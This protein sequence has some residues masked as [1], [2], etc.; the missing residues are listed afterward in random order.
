MKRILLLLAACAWMAQNIFAD[1]LDIKIGQMILMGI[2]QRKSI[3]DNDSLLLDIKAG[4]LGGVL[5]F[6]KNIS[7]SNATQKLKDLCAKLQSAANIP[8]FISIDEEGGKVHRLKEKYGFVAMP[9][10]S[11]LGKINNIDSTYYYNNRLASELASLGINLNFAPSVDLRVNE[12]NKVIVQTGRSFSSDPFIVANNANA[13][14]NAHHN[15]GVYTSLKHFPGHGSSLD[16]SHLGLV[17]V[18]NTWSFEELLPYYQILKNGNCDAVMIA[19]LINKNWDTTKT[20]STLSYRVVTDILRNLIG[21][22]GLTF[23]DDMQ[24]KAITKFY[25]LETAIEKAINAGIDVVMFGNN[26]F[27]SDKV[28]LSQVHAIIKNLVLSGK[29]PE[30]RINESYQRIIALKSKC[31]H[32][33]LNIPHTSSSLSKNKHSKKTKYLLLAGAQYEI[34][35]GLFENERKE[36]L[37]QFS[38]YASGLSTQHVQL[39]YEI[40]E[41]VFDDQSAIQFLSARIDSLLNM[42]ASKNIYIAINENQISLIDALNAKYP[43]LKFNFVITGNERKADMSKWKKS[44]NTFYVF[45]PKQLKDESHQKNIKYIHV[46]TVKTNEFMNIFNW[47]DPWME[48]MKWKKTAKLEK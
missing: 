21:Y 16:D 22:K 29:I 7:D 11:N 34:H 19:H 15:N 46:G 28:S 1:S 39:V 20:P 47:I 13:C 12:K 40:G 45:T 33:Y 37:H 32:N 18:S 38:L 48:T 6:E 26:V 2:D 14:I 43:K 10:A 25:G 31:Y 42:G 44:K 5:L 23:S 24:M 27:Q 41:K 36:N 3:A 30:S 35:K 4:K 17:D 8:L 9:S